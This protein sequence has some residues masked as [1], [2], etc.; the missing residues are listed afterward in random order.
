MQAVYGTRNW[1]VIIVQLLRRVRLFA[2]PWTTAY[3]ASLSS[4]ISQSLL[5]FMSIEWSWYVGIAMYLYFLI[6]K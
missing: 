5:K 2:M 4:T 3:Q 1:V 6:E